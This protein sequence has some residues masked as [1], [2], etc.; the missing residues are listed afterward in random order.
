M[1]T[2]TRSEFRKQI[3]IKRNALSG[4]QQTQSGIDLVKQCMQLDE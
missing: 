4:D 2:L 1:K 3:R